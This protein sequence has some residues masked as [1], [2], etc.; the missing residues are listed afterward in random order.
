MFEIQ[1]PFVELTSPDYDP[2]LWAEFYFAVIE[3]VALLLRSPL[4]LHYLLVN[5]VMV[6]FHLLSGKLRLMLV[7]Y[8]QLLFDSVPLNLLLETFN[9]LLPYP[10]YV[11]TQG[12]ARW[13]YC[14]WVFCPQDANGAKVVELESVV[15]DTHTVCREERIGAYNSW[16]RER[17]YD[18]TIG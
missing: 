4:M 7:Q 8:V 2:D 9:V 16:S 1:D 11:T 13:P 6:P 12:S 15:S 14:F 10:G 3:F 18:A 5:L 17:T